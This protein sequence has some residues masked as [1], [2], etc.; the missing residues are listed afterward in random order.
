MSLCKHAHGEAEVIEGANGQKD[1]V[2]EHKHD[3]CKDCTKLKKQ[4]KKLLLEID[5]KNELI[6]DQ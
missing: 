1:K 3:A 6:E 5:Q 2:H 4:N